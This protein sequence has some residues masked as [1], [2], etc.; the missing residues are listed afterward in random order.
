M[1]DLDL[2]DLADCVET[3]EQA[4]ARLEEVEDQLARRLGLGRRLIRRELIALDRRGE[5]VEDELVALWHELHSNYV[6]WTRPDTWT[7]PSP[8][9]A[10]G[11]TV[12]SEKRAAEAALLLL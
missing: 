6:D 11:A 5:L 1:L 9:T 4:K 12:E 3:Y 7:E 10:A 8:K 2:R